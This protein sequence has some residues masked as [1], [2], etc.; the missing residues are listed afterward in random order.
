MNGINNPNFGSRFSKPIRNGIPITTEKINML[1]FKQEFRPLV[2]ELLNCYINKNDEEDVAALKIFRTDYNTP[3][4][5]HLPNLLNIIRRRQY[6][7]WS[8]HFNKECRIDYYEQ[9]G[10]QALKALV[11]NLDQLLFPWESQDIGEAK[12]QATQDQATGRQRKK[13][14]EDQE[15]IKTQV[16]LGFALFN[17]PAQT[18]TQ[19]PTQ[20]KSSLGK[21]PAQP[22]PSEAPSQAIGGK[23]HKTNQA[24]LGIKELFESSDNPLNQAISSLGKRPAQ[25]NPSEDSGQQH[26]QANVKKEN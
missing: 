22:N 26:I 2:Y 1:E 7:Y 18:P 6:Y 23:R 24:A 16:A 11:L 4:R 5:D 3:D 9:F 12:N 8:D 13:E 19:T 10:S 14:L 20:T 15:S 25:P 21:R 17:G